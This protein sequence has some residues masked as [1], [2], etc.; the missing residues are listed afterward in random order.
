MEKQSNIRYSIEGNSVKPPELTA[1][2]T[3]GKIEYTLPGWAGLIKINKSDEPRIY[4]SSRGK[5]Y[6]EESND[7]W[8]C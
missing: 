8:S 5:F 2:L 6:A 4:N 1:N 3:R 7:I